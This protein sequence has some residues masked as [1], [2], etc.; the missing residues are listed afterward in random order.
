MSEKVDI[1][2]HKDGSITLDIDTGN[3]QCSDRA[4]EFIAKMEEFGVT[5]TITNVQTDIS[6]DD[7]QRIRQHC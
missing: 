6:D 7:G 1:Q 5:P 2:V 4:K 3:G